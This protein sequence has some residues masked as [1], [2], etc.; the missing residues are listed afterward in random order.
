MDISADIRAAFAAFRKDAWCQLQV[1][2]R[3]KASE[4]IQALFRDH[5]E[6]IPVGVF[7]HE[8]WQIGGEALLDGK[9][10]PLYSST[11][12]P[13]ADPQQLQTALAADVL[14]THGNLAWASGSSVYGPKM[15]PEAR[16]EALRQAEAVLLDG[17]QL[18]AS[19]HEALKALPGFGDNIA[20]GL[21]MMFHPT[22]YAIEN[23]P[24]RKALRWLGAGQLTGP[25]FQQAMTD[26]RQK[27]GST[28]FLE[29][30]W[31]LYRLQDGAYP[32]ALRWYGGLTARLPERASAQRVAARTAAEE[33]ARAL[34][35]DGAEWD[36]DKLGRFLDAVN[37]DWTE[38]KPRKDRFN[39][40]FSGNNRSL[41]LKE[42][43][44]VG[45]VITGLFSAGRADLPAL[46]K[47]SLKQHPSG[48]GKG[49][50]TLALYLRDPETYAIWLDTVGASLRHWTG[51]TREAG[52]WDSYSD[53]CDEVRQIRP[54]LRC[55]PQAMDA[56]LWEVSV[57]SPPPNPP[58]ALPA[59]NL[60]YYGP[61]GTGKTYRVLTELARNRFTDRAVTETP[62]QFAAALVGDL[63]W[64]QVITMVMLDLGEAKVTDILGHDLM[65]AKVGQSAT[66]HARESVWAHL[67]QHTRLDCPNVAVQKRFEPLLFAKD[68]GSVWT[69][70]KQV[71]AETVPDL[72]DKLEL[73]RSF[74]P[75]AVD[76]KRYGFITFHQSYSYEDFVEG[77]RPVMAE[78]DMEVDG[79]LGYKVQ[80]GVFR[81]ICRRAAADP[82]KEYALFIDEI[83]RGNVAGIFGE[84]ITLI[85]EDKRLGAANEIVVT[86][87]YSKATF[88]VPPN[89]YIVG[90][91][92][93][94]DRSVEALDTALRRRF[95]FVE[96][97][98]DY[99]LLREQQPMDL[100]V[101]LAR[102]LETINDRVEQLVDRDH[103]VGHSYLLEVK[104]LAD[105]RF[106]FRNKILPLLQEYFYGNPTRLGRVLGEGFLTMPEQRTVL[107]K[108]P[109]GDDDTDPE[110]QVYRLVPAAE[111]TAD[112]FI[113]VYTD[114]D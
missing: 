72:L 51:L 34:I 110:R 12:G 90:T 67:Q 98:P 93:S 85:E 10:I 114:H 57:P 8:V 46:F 63:P 33:E 39:Q 44:P 83:N 42:A 53:F 37:R 71:A 40:A 102:L 78:E 88:G 22:Q 100:G 65:L 103:C 3:R 30:D 15:A 54:V 91:M 5:P 104:T 69:I 55:E 24:S 79:N 95:A 13:G 60:I 36:A 112:S 89:L 113:S 76:E 75:T 50:L 109:W 19:Q 48:V 84:L 74:T 94:A 4:R 101:D 107:A 32:R 18:P 59:H 81:D 11:P 35:R 27:L 31:F 66:S 82:G 41:M 73:Y 16:A 111:W 21:V 47:Q 58:V 26:V 2:C 87:P 1:A 108:G 49:I 7:N 99:T 52:S 14:E 70:D 28:D 96:C 77:I 23:D 64:W 9:R 105:L 25:A 86:L 38:G 6:G 97:R 20:S 80:A 61:P 106:A 45:E 17:G 62:A 43:K 56:L 68:A 29:L 92:N